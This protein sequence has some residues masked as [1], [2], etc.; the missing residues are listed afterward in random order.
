MPT[1]K[2]KI[3]LPD[4]VSVPS[5]SGEPSSKRSTTSIH[6]HVDCF[7]LAS[8]RPSTQTSYVSTVEPTLNLSTTESSNVDVESEAFTTLQEFLDPEY[9]IDCA[10][11]HPDH[12]TPRNRS[13][14]G[15]RLRTVLNL[16]CILSTFHSQDHPM[17][18]WIPEID[19]WLH[20]LMRLE[21]R[22]DH[23]NSTCPHCHTVQGDYRCRDCD[24]LALF[25]KSCVVE[26][27]AHLPT[28][29]IMVSLSFQNI[30]PN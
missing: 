26:M 7:H 27:H 20:E 29:R 3:P 25:C 22:G 21:G 9:F 2:R 1:R 6:Q 28:H 10:I 24:N 12:V 17:Q 5:E 19:T 18:D 4:L 16:N 11:D 8:G 14:A 30:N 15:V 23:C 13:A